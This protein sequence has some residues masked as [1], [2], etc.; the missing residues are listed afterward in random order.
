MSWFLDMFSEEVQR[1]GGRTW[2]ENF[3]TLALSL[4]PD[5]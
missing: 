5:Y 4:K 2:E 3:A 1:K